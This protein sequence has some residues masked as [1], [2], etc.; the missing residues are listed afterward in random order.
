MT[1][2]AAFAAGHARRGLLIDYGGVLTTDVF[3]SFH[4]FERTAGLEHGAVV[5]L[6]RG[7]A[8]AAA[9]LAELETG[10]TPVPAIETALAALLGVPGTRLLERMFGGMRPQPAMWEAVRALRDRGVRTALVSNS[11]GLDGY[12]ARLSE[13]FDAMVISGDVGL[14]KPD[15]QIYLLGA[16]RIG[17]PPGDCVFVDDLPGNLVPAARLGMAVIRHTD[18]ASSVAALAD[19]FDLEPEVL[20]AGPAQSR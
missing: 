2:A 7:D 12:P 17:L 19:V 15:P 3:E 11:W 18:P 5:R 4:A 20:A 14:R 6:L 16:A 8:R 1:F 10:A 13:L 9:L